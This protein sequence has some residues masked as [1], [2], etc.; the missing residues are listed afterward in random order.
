MVRVKGERFPTLSAIVVILMICGAF[1]SPPDSAAVIT[2][3]L[4]HDTARTREMLKE[5]IGG[6]ALGGREA[7]PTGAATTAQGD[8]ES[9]WFTREKYLQ[10]GEAEKAQQQLQLLWEKSMEHGIRNLPEYGAVLVREAQRRMQTRDYDQAA[11]ALGFARKIAPDEVPVFTTG[12]L[13]AVKRNP[14]NIGAVWEEWVQAAHAVRGSFRLQAWLRANIWFTVTAGL[15]FFCAFA[16]G[17]LTVTAA[18]RAAHDFRELIPVGSPRAR[19]VLAWMALAAPALVGLSPWWWLMIGGLVVWPYLDRV[20]RVLLALGGLLVL[21]WPWIVRES[22][23]YLTLPSQP[24]LEKVVLLREGHWSAAD[25]RELKTLAEKGAGGVP[26]VTELGIAARRLGRLDEAEAAIREGLKAASSDPALWINLGNIA[27]ARQDAA[28]AVAH[29]AKAA[30]IAPQLFA[31]HFNLGVVYR[32]MFKFTEGEAESRRAGEID[33]E[34][35]VYYAGLDAARLK[36][37]TLDGLPPP[38]AI[39]ELARVRS[40]EREAAAELLWESLMLGPSMRLWP[41]VA[42]ALL[43]LGGAAGL[44]RLRSGAARECE[45]CGRIFCARCQA[46]KRGGLCSQCHHIFVKKEGVDAKVRIQKMAGIKTHRRLLKIRHIIFAVL[47]PGGGHLSAGRFRTGVVFLLPAAFFEVRFLFGRSAFPSPW[48]LGSAAASSFAA[49]GMVIFG[50]WW[51]VSL[52][53]ATRLE[54]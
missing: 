47:A 45:R 8:L 51:A 36:G 3:D 40:D 29:Y 30:E 39:W 42:V 33:P 21:A 43:A 35:V 16:A 44:W 22:A 5:E 19:T 34:G 9:I 50:L 2:F 38:G 7:A 52:W 49:V 25:Y 1:L 4:L 11:R 20:P 37:Y 28:G 31:P 24:V 23:V 14:F 13:L 15:A 27:F 53:L 18:P 26:A 46:G 6:T 12:A 32:E 41:L 17:V 10:I 48:S 54:E